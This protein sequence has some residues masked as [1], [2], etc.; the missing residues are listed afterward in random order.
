[1]IDIGDILVCSVENN[2]DGSLTL[3]C[4]I[5]KGEQDYGSYEGIVVDEEKAKKSPCY[6]VDGTNLVFSE[7]IIGALNEEQKEKY[8]PV[9]YERKPHSEKICV[10]IENI[11]EL[12]REIE[13][14]IEKGK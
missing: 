13:R 9:I 5:I 4:S 14:R 10:N 11:D 1:M 6:R 3:K 8:C 2:K 7:G 12:I